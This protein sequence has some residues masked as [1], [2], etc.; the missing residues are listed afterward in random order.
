M[1][2]ISVCSYIW[3]NMCVCMNLYVY[4]S[5]CILFLSIYIIGG[6]C[7]CVSVTLNV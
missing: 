7:I 6:I 3:I 5:I 4:M 1:M 2:C